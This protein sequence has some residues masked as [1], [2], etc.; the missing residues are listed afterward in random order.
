M[1]P[2]TEATVMISELFDAW[3][4]KGVEESLVDRVRHSAEGVVIVVDYVI[5]CVVDD[6]RV[7]YVVNLSSIRKFSII[8]VKS[9]FNFEDHR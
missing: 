6:G 5:S 3:G 4:I 9:L 2:R 1:I 7:N 8:L